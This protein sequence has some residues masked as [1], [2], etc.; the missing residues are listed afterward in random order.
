VAQPRVA[1]VI[2]L[3]WNGTQLRVKGSVSYSI[4][5]TKREL[6]FG[7]DGPHG[8]KDMPQAQ[9]VEA[10]LTDVS[11]LD[12]RALF[13]QSAATIAL[14]LANGKT[15]GLRDAIFAGDGSVT[16]EE[17]EIAARWEGTDAFE[18]LP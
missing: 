17:S 7:A 10:T 1:G 12:T 3:Y 18:L 4:N 15:V 8:Y 9:Y 13:A 2:A 6:V 14:H 16:T 5:P 11:D